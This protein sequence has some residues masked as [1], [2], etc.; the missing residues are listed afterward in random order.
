[1]E[2]QTVRLGER[3]TLNLLERLGNMLVDE[4]KMAACSL[5]KEITEQC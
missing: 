5:G 1:M 4:P 2:V 3:W